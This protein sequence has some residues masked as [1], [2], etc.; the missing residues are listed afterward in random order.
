MEDD[1]GRCWWRR[2]DNLLC[3]SNHPCHYVIAVVPVMQANIDSA[4]SRVSEGSIPLL[5]G[6]RWLPDSP[7][8]ETYL[9]SDSPHQ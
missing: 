6:K 9:L 1:D 5:D 3:S 4:E 2:Q 8:L 7:I